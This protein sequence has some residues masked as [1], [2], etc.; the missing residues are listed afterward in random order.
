MHRQARVV[1]QQSFLSVYA[2]ILLLST[3]MSLV[4]VIGRTDDDLISVLDTISA[5]E[6]TLK[7]SLFM[8][9][10]VASPVSDSD[11][12][13]LRVSNIY[14]QLPRLLKAV[15]KQRRKIDLKL[16]KNGNKRRRQLRIDLLWLETSIAL[17][18]GDL[19]AAADDNGC[20]ARGQRLVELVAPA[21]F[22]HGCGSEW[23]LET[24]ERL[25]LCRWRRRHHHLRATSLQQN[26]VRLLESH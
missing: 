17:H 22:I 18:I 23:V 14:L 4:T 9:S 16:K 26:A 12:P 2:V 5:N 6:K 24:C 13:R 10:A 3:S 15:R 8:D 25:I 21:D 19:G 1:C 20:E 7:P 11:S